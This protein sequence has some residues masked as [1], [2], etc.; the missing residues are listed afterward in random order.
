MTACSAAISGTPAEKYGLADLVPR[1]KHC[2]QAARGTPCER[3]QQKHDLGNARDVV[4]ATIPY[5]NQ[6]V[7]HKCQKRR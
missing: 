2:Q 4:S 6:L 1:H 7:D 3:K 5:G